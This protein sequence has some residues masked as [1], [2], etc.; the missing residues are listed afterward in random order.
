MA[1]TSDDDHLRLASLD[2]KPLPRRNTSLAFIQS[3]LRRLSGSPSG[4]RT[5][6]PVDIKGPLGLNLL[7]EPSEPRVDFIF[8]HGLFGGSRKTWSYS[9]EQGMFWPKDWLPNE[10]GFRHVRLHSYGYNSGG[11]RRESLLTVHDFAQALLAD[12]YNSPDLRKNGDTPI[13]FVAHSM[14]GLVVKKAY[15]LALNDDF[16]YKRIG[17]RIHTMYFLGTPHR[18]ADLAQIVRIIR[19]SAGHGS[20][21]YVDDLVPGSEALN[22]INDEFRHVCSNLHLWS[23]FEGAPTAFGPL[24]TLVVKKESAILGLPGEH[25]QYVEADHRH[26][27]K[28]ESPSSPNYVL[29]QRAFL[30]AIEKLEADSLFQRR[31]EYREQMQQVSSFLLV[32]H[33]P[34]AVL[35]AINGK[36]HQGS[37]QWLT[38]DEAFQRWINGPDRTGYAGPPQQIEEEAKIL[39]LTGRPGTGKSVVSGHVVQYLEDC[40]LDCSFYLF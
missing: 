40:N 34:D 29:L 4:G 28:F 24:S 15:L 22:Q 16:I 6:S 35:S 10:V 21:A 26:L 27:C 18:G 5:L 39:W 23:F 14:G 20:K 17:H 32:E 13:V 7:H 1:S 2:N 37:C 30:T 38:A 3:K 33:R 19:Y 31:D 36:Q 12:I 11:S 25:I 8:V 9:Q